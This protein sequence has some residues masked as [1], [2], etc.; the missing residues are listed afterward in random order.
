LLAG[1]AFPDR[2][3]D[4]G[5]LGDTKKDRPGDERDDKAEATRL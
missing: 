2:A 1:H 5:A 4:L 3:Q